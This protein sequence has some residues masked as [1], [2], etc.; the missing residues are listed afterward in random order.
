MLGYAVFAVKND[1]FVLFLLM[2]VDSQLTGL[3][4]TR[5][6]RHRLLVRCLTLP[7]IFAV[8]FYLACKKC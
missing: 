3:I 2:M 5:D 8:S 6:F 7:S 1:R 4:A